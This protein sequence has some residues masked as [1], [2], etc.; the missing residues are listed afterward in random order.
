MSDASLLLDH[1]LKTEKSNPSQEIWAVGGGKGGV[2]KSLF[3][4]N[5]SIFLA[6]LGKKVVAIDLDLGG[7]NLHTCLGVPIPEKTLSDYVNN[8]VGC[9]DDLIVPTAIKN[10][11]LISGAQDSMGIANLRR[12]QK[13]KLMRKIN[14]INADYV[15]FDLGAGTSFNTLDFFIMAHKGILVTLPE[16][17]AIENTY[18]FIKSMHHRNLILIEELLGIRPMINKAINSKLGVSEYS[19]HSLNEIIKKDPGDSKKI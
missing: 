6:L 14:K 16:P 2:G 4:A 10:L 9:L 13:V 19:S 7:A 8:T 5:A 1:S 17:T 3:A 18:R 12:I 15:I 11:S